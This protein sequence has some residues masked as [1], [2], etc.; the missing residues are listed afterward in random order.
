MALSTIAG[1][2]GGGILLTCILNEGAPTVSSR[3]YSKGNSR[4]AVTTWAAEI[5][6]GDVVALAND[7]DCTYTATSGL[8]VVEA[9][10]NGETLV[11]G[12]IMSEPQMM[13]QPV[14]A[15]ATTL[16]NRLTYGY[17]RIATVECWCAHSVQKAQVLTTDTAAIVPGVGATVKVDVSASYTNHKLTVTDAASGGVGCIPLHYLAKVAAGDYN[18]LLAITDLMIAI[19]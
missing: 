5:Y 7:S 1:E 19:S 6:I 2:V 11:F 3:A 12:Q 16:A 4:I 8:P 15:S 9:P 18:I 13:K 14:Q 17:Y 10:V